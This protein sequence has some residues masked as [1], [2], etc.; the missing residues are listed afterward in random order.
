MHLL[1]T[2]DLQVKLAKAVCQA[3]FLSF[4]RVCH[5]CVHE[6]VHGCQWACSEGAAGMGTGHRCTGLCGSLG[7][8]LCLC[9]FEHECVRVHIRFTVPECVCEGAHVHPGTPQ[10]AGLACFLCWGFGIIDPKPDSLT[11]LAS[12]L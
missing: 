7:A 8:L 2:G 10:A 11:D 9:I 5:L 4:P 3:G 12:W 1:G 6:C